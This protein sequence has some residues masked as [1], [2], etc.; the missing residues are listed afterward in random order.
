MATFR[1]E[2]N[3]RGKDRQFHDNNYAKQAPECLC[4][5]QAKKNGLKMTHH[6]ETARIVLAFEIFK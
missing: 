4:C 6:N 2:R 1:H 3:T 5:T